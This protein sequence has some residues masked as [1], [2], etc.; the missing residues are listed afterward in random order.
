MSISNG[1]EDGVQNDFRSRHVQKKRGKGKGVVVGLSWA[2][3]EFNTG[4]ISP[5]RGAITLI[6]CFNNTH[7]L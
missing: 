1:V 3:T 2:V 6:A 7:T 4:R 5:C